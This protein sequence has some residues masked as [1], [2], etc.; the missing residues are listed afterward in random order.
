MALSPFTGKAERVLAELPSQGYPTLAVYSFRPAGIVPIHPVPEAPWFYRPPLL[1]V[2]KGLGALYPP[3][4][5]KTNVLAQGM[6]AAVLKGGQ[7]DVPGWP[8]KGAVGNDGVF[9]NEEIKKL[10]VE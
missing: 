4:V 2:I 9:D 8:G 1:S 5:I 7:G 6:L 3:M 10:A